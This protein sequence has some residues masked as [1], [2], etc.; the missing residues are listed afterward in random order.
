MTKVLC[1]CFSAIPILS[2]ELF[3]TICELHN[4]GQRADKHSE[5]EN[6]GFFFLALFL[7]VMAAFVYLA[8]IFGWLSALWCVAKNGREQTFAVLVR[9]YLSYDCFIGRLELQWLCRP[10]TPFF[11]P[12]CAAFRMDGFFSF[13]CY[14][15]HSGLPHKPCMFMASALL[16]RSF[17][18]FLRWRV[19]SVP[20]VTGPNF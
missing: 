13:S 16:P 3:K 9:T 12:F 10:S 18:R 1:L 11:I 7:A 8:H 19:F 4:G 15:S 17:L 20:M 6:C 5:V 14:S 2:I